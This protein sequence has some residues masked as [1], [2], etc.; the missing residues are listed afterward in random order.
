[1]QGLAGDTPIRRG[2]ASQNAP[3]K[4]GD[5]GESVI[6]GLGFGGATVERPRE[7]QGLGEKIVGFLGS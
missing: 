4:A 7:E 5:V 2:N 6:G 3:G 1:M